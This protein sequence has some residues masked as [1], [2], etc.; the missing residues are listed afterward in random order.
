MTCICAKLV[1]DA[2]ANHSIMSHWIYFCILAVLVLK[3]TSLINL[4]IMKKYPINEYCAHAEMSQTVCVLSTSSGLHQKCLLYK[5]IFTIPW[6]KNYI[7]NL[8]K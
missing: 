5:L 7:G 6:C 8:R 2:H 4:K 1:G 3:T